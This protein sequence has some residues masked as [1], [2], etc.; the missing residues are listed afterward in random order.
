[1][2][3]LGRVRLAQGRLEDA[4]N[5]FRQSMQA[6]GDLP[7]PHY[8]LALCLTRQNKLD[9]AI[10]E[11]RRAIQIEPDYLDAYLSIG[12]ALIEKGDADGAIHEYQHVLAVDPDNAVAENDLAWIYS[13]RKDTQKRDPKASLEHARHAVELLQHASKVLPE[14]NAA[15]L[16]TLAEALLINGQVDDALKTEEF[17]LQIDPH[18]PILKSRLERFR[19][20]AQSGRP[21]EEQ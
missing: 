10:A 21:P 15:F 7:D 9:E 19:I 6:D 20:A 3:A 5:E 11:N 14:Q 18:N 1:M 13:T 8:N 2:N 4:M 12:D 17:A 16:D